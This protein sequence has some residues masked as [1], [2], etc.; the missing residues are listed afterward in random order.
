M[1]RNNMVVSVGEVGS[2]YYAQCSFMGY[3][4]GITY[5][6]LADEQGKAIH[7]TTP[8]PLP[9]EYAFLLLF[10]AEV[11]RT[12]KILDIVNVQYGGVIFTF[13]RDTSQ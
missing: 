11:E 1:A 7:Y 12:N 5:N 8:D 13:S 10:M 9:T 2:A 6:Y 3:G 4:N